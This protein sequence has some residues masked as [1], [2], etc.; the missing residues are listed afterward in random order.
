MKDF[1]AHNHD[2]PSDQLTGVSAFWSSIK[3]T[4]APLNF[5]DLIA[6]AIHRT[7]LEDFGDPPYEDALRV[8]INACNYEANLSLFGQFV[9][10]HHLLDLLKTRL[11]LVSY[12]QQKPEILE[13]PIRQPVFIT[14]MPRS[15]STLLH[16]LFAQDPRNRIPRT[17]E[18][19]FP[20]PP[21]S[22]KESDFDPRILK[23]EKQLRL[24]IWIRPAIMKVHPIGASLPQE[25]IAILSYSFQ[26]DEF[27]CMFQIPSYEVWLRAHDLGKAY[28][29]HQRFLKHMQW[30]CPGK[31]WVLKAPDHVH[32]MEALLRTYP[33][34]RFVFL[35][36]DPL[37]VLGSVASL[38]KI[39]RGAFSHHIDFRQVV[40]NEAFNLAEKVK[41]IIEFQDRSKHLADYF[42]NVNYLNLIRNPIPTMQQI[43]NHFGLNLSDIA[44]RHMHILLNARHNKKRPRHFY[45]L[46]DL[47]LDQ[48]RNVPLFAAYYERFAI[49]RETP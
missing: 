44:E 21:P 5:D 41:K 3:Q 42:I 36:R 12:W 20:L 43:Y 10:H 27:L 15:G 26:S 35:H 34:A 32:S 29:F 16:N 47:E 14:G 38:T 46:T 40:A 7:H 19:M 13:Q 31:Q 24:L 2:Q 33:D 23:A 25:C 17:W 18:V 28:E 37:K 30:L 11:K 45:R 39:L 8:L 48:Y 9:V 4:L 22:C 1:L 6:Q 49:E